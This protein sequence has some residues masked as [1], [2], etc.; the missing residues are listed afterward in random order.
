VGEAGIDESPDLPNLFAKLLSAGTRRLFRR[1]LDRGY[2]AFTDEVENPRGRLRLDRMVKEATQIRSKAVCD[3]DELT[4][5]V[6]HNQVLKATL[7][8]LAKCSDVEKETRH[9]LRSLARRFYD[10]AD[11]LLSGSCFRSI[12]VSR[13][14]REYIFLMLLCEF[15]FWSLMP[16]ERG[17]AA[18]FKQV[19]E[20]EVRMSVVFEDFLRNFFQAHRTEYRVRVE[21]SEWFVSDASEHDLALLP[22]MVTDIT[23]RHPDHTIIIDAKFYGKALAQGPFGERVRSQHLYQLV[24]YL[25]HERIRQTERRLAGIL[26]YPDV[27]RSL[28]LR[29]RLLGIPVLVATVDLGQEWRN[30]EAELHGLLDQCASAASLRHETPSSAHDGS[31][32][33]VARMP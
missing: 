25:Q 31:G 9:E 33:S 23:L 16:D 10:V 28:R 1:G 24:T 4:H 11:I 14:N 2:K 15:V 26:I 5:D 12:V 17:T 3:F 20:D 6:L 13:N 19:L 7:V 18:R 32:R 29:Y 22:R 30:I 27:G 8:E 21:S